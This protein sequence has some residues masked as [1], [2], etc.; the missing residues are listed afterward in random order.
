MDFGAIISFIAIIL[1]SSLFNKDKKT[2]KTSRTSRTFKAPVQPNRSN[3][4]NGTAKQGP[5][6]NRRSLSGGLEDLFKELRTEFDKTFSD[7]ESNQHTYTLEEEASSIKMENDYKEEDTKERKSKD[8]S[9][10]YKN[11]VYAGEIGKNEVSIEFNR[12]SIIQ[13]VIMSEI[14]QKPKS[15][16]R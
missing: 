6:V 7:N 15:L 5:N 16:R 9:E 14:L 1:I 3:L 2:A 11:S 12:K 8:T 4:P 13:G 10:I